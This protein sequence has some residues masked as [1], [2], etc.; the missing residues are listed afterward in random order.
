MTWPKYTKSNGEFV[1]PGQ[2]WYLA[3]MSEANN[4]YNGIW[5]K[6]GC[7][8]SILVVLSIIAVIGLL[9]YNLFLGS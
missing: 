4:D 2:I 5:M 7:L 3:S 8:L 9:G 1:G 6:V